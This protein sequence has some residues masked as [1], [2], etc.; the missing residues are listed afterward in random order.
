M[1]R[2][3]TPKGRSADTHREG[4]GWAP[5]WG[6]ELYNLRQG[7]TPSHSSGDG[8][9]PHGSIDVPPFLVRGQA[10]QPV[11]IGLGWYQLTLPATV[12]APATTTTELVAQVGLLGNHKKG[13]SLSQFQ[14]GHVSKKRRGHVTMSVPAPNP[15]NQWGGGPG[16]YLQIGKGGDRSWS[17][18]AY[19]HPPSPKA[20]NHKRMVAT[21]SR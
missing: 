17:N 4:G 18:R 8:Q 12:E 7:N 6:T 21:D 19:S 3:C 11:Q 2:R 5:V 16:G 10:P 1:R 9:Q 20:R 13:S 14:L 15:V